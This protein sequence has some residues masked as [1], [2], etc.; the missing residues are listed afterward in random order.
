MP[1]MA[2]AWL[3]FI[4]WKGYGNVYMLSLDEFCRYLYLHHLFVIM[5][6]LIR[7]KSA[8]CVYVVIRNGYF[9]LGKKFGKR[10]NENF[11]RMFHVGH[12][13]M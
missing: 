11:V 1:V 12:D 7:L 5:L 6:R 4:V 2:R 9:M 8:W 13:W 3:L 10:G